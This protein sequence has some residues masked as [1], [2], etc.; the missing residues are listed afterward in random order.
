MAIVS[1]GLCSQLTTRGRKL[2]LK[3]TGST[4]SNSIMRPPPLNVALPG[5][6][7]PPAENLAVSLLAD[8]FGEVSI[9]GKRSEPEKYQ[10]VR[11]YFQFYIEVVLYLPYDEWELSSDQ[12]TDWVKR[13]RARMSREE[14]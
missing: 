10:A 11:H 13:Q 6:I 5:Y 14:R 4:L 2:L 9:R 3:H 1:I 12:I 8:Y 7:G